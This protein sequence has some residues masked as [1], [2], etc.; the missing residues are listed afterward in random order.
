M[1]LWGRVS[2]SVVIA[3]GFSMA[4]TTFL[5]NKVYYEGH[6]WQICLLLFI[7]GTILWPIGLTLRR[8]SGVNDPA[9]LKRSR[10]F[11]EEQATPRPFVLIDPAY[12]GVMLV[13]FSVILAVIS[14][15][16]CLQ[17]KVVAA[18]A[19]PEGSQTTNSPTNA[20]IASSPET[21][22]P[23][24]TVGPERLRLQGVV[25]L[26]RNPSALISGRTYFVGD[27]VGKA[28]VVMIEAGRVVLE[29][30]GTPKVLELGK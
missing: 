10:V 14:P 20:V 5:Q 22:S 21:L 11:E 29:Q 8:P 12:W 3:A 30:E 16:S 26:A 9:G 6:K 1:N 27:Y 2:L 19:I 28:K 25:Y 17:P 4:V 15:S 23:M 18:R 7:A 13:V 24:E